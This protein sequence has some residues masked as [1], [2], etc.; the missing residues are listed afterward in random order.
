MIL[1]LKLGAGARTQKGKTI[2]L[3]EL[4]ASRFAIGG[5]PLRTSFL[6]WVFVQAIGIPSI[7]STTMA[8]TNPAT[9]DG[10]LALSKD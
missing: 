2:K 1:G 10:R 8:T 4:G 7:A 5:K 6:T 9:V 3:M